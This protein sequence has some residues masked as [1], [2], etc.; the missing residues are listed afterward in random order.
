MMMTASGLKVRRNNSYDN[1]WTDENSVTLDLAA[2]S[3]RMDGISANIE[4]GIS[5]IFED[6]EFGEKYTVIYPENPLLYSWDFT[7]SLT[8]TVSGLTATVSGAAR[9]EE[10]LLLDGDGDYC[11]LGDVFAPGRSIEFDVAESSA[12]FAASSHGRCFMIYTPDVKGTE[13]LI[14]RHQTGAWSFY[15][16]SGWDSSLPL[17][18]R[19]AFAGKTVR[20][21]SDAEGYISLYVDGEFIAKSGIAFDS[22]RTRVAIGSEYTGSFND[23]RITGVRVY[24]EEEEK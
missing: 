22:S 5:L 23:I 20:L 16:N 6:T 15:A 19:N 17:T 1:N 3:D 13:G 8:D 21:S 12:D 24:K 14:W 11:I 4:G 18:D 2:M 7:S 10:G 9:D